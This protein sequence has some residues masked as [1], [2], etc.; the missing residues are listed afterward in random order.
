MFYKIL[1]VL[2]AIALRPF[3]GR[4]GKKSYIGKPL[5]LLG[6]KKAF[7]GNK[8]RIFPHSRIEVHESGV[9]RIE[10]NVSIGQ[11]FHVI[12][13]EKVTISSGSLL[14]ANVFIT[15]TDHTFSDLSKPVH[16]QP[17]ITKETKIGKNCF[18]GY[19]VVIQA[20]T[21]LGDNCV[22]GAN[23]TVKGHFGDGEIIVG[24][25]GRVIKNRN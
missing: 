22:V 3:F 16:E 15:D 4:I 20:G 24:S 9:L 10:E 19:G 12:C 2:R 21:V 5:F 7:L 6:V 11:S 18:I 25:P 13:S 8:V 14:S 17:N 23:S 1:W